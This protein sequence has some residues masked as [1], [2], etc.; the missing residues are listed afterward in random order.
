MFRRVHITKATLDALN[1][2]YIV[3]EGHGDERSRYLADHHVDTY[4]V[5]EPKNKTGA[6][7]PAA[8]LVSCTVIP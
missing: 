7:H 6:A 1:G 8:R 5:V 2:E 4:L 3:E